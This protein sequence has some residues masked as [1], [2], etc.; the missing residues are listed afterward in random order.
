MEERRGIK[1]VID[2]TSYNTKTASLIHF[3]NRTDRP[4]LPGRL[5]G[6]YDEALYRTLSGSFFVVKYEHPASWNKDTH[7]HELGDVIF[8]L[9]DKDVRDWFGLNCPEKLDDFLE[10]SDIPKSQGGTLTIRIDPI[11]KAK[12][13][14]KASLSGQSL[15]LMC[16][17]ILSYLED[18]PIKYKDV[19][20]GDFKFWDGSDVLTDVG[21]A[22]EHG[23][24]TKNE[25][26]KIAA[27]LYLRSKNE[28]YS[29]DAYIVYI[30]SKLHQRNRLSA[31]SAVQRW[32]YVFIKHQVG[33]GD[34]HNALDNTR[35]Y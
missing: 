23:D 33:S 21:L 29:L 24:D 32:L 12:L 4:P 9:N 6:G 26:S 19:S 27:S 5:Q 35:E 11:L 16:A 22:K 13:A 3:K 7:T 2:G 20:P 30:I 10:N 8:P 18:P 25:L 34:P 17:Q 1:R 31:L 14:A 15:N 28:R